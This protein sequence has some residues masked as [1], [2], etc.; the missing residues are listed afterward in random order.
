MMRDVA[1][2]EP[3]DDPHLPERPAA[4]ELTA[5]D[6]RGELGELLEPA[7]RGKGS[8]ADV[9]V[10][11]EVGVLDPHRVVHAERDVDDAPA[12]RLEARQAFGDE[13]PH[14]V[15]GEAAGDVRRVEDHR[16]HHVHVRRRG[17]E[18]EERGVEPGQPLHTRLLIAAA[19]A[20]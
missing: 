15:D 6:L 17:L 1:V 12:E 4:V 7:R 8:P 9:V 16:R 18:G 14:R 5:G 2:L 20:A 3:F 19:A 13:L 11:I 10:E